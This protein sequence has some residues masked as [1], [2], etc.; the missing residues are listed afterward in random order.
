[1]KRL[2]PLLLVAAMLVPLAAFAQQ[3]MGP[4]PLLQIIREDVKPGKGIAHEK[5]ETSWTQ[6][7]VHAKYTTPGIGMTAVTGPNE[8]WFISGFADLAAFE[9]DQKKL[10]TDPA[11]KAVMQQY[12]PGDADYISG[13]RTILA[14][15]REDLSY[16]AGNINIGEM[17]YFQVTTVRIRPGHMNEFEEFSKVL[18]AARDKANAKNLHIAVFQAI[19]GAPS[20]TLYICRPSKT[21]AELVPNPDVAKA[22]GDEGNAKLDD[23]SGKSVIVSEAAIFAFSPGMSIPSPDMV[24]A[25]SAFW[26]PKPAAATAS[27]GGEKKTEKK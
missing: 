26:K 16:N 1:M 10:Y 14:R 19:S 21:M 24:A 2:T 18:N 22:L 11:T 9:A 3:H 23:L 4:P 27:K 25:D 17:R 20:G 8:A 13:T 6:A 15:Y 12:A 7:F 5:Y